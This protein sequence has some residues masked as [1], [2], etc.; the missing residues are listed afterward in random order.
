MTTKEVAQA[1]E[2][3][4]ADAAGFTSSFSTPP[5][6]LTE[7]MPLVIAEVQAKRRGAEATEFPAR[8]F[9]QTSIRVWSVELTLLVSPDPSWTA[10]HALYDAIDALEASLYKDES[11]GA[12]VAFAQKAVDSG[13]EPPEIE[14]AD[15]TVARQATFRIIVGEL[16]EA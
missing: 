1:V 3:W 5:V 16:L 4:A 11:L 8:G 12:R 9:Q 7:V 2:E 10:S 14:F 13:F 15:G 6:S